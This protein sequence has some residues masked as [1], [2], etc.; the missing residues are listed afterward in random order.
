MGIRIRGLEEPVSGRGEGGSGSPLSQS[1]GAVDWLHLQP[2]P[3]PALRDNNTG[4][5]KLFLF[6]LTF[7][8]RLHKWLFSF[9]LVSAKNTYLC[10]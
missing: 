2:D 5:A 6:C 9:H 4:W 10:R 7:G 1:C 8:Y 3:N